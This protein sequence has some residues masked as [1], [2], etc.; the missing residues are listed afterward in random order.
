MCY[1]ANVLCTYL[2]CRAK[3]NKIK[4]L[5]VTYTQ[6]H[7]YTHTQHL[8]KKILP[9]FPWEVYRGSL[10]NNRLSQLNRTPS[11]ICQHQIFIRA[12]T[13]YLCYN[14]PRPTSCPATPW[15]TPSRAKSFISESMNSRWLHFWLSVSL[16]FSDATSAMFSLIRLWMSIYNKIHNLEWAT[17]QT[18]W[19]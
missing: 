16:Y 9:N 13:Q 17:N 7:S 3:H 15:R 11:S 1:S 4:T 6:T 14:D 10:N 5:K 8:H 12:V 2:H 19:K 18:K